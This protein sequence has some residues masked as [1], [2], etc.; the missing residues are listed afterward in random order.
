M[1]ENEFNSMKQFMQTVGL[2]IDDVAWTIGRTETI[3][4]ASRFGYVN[5]E[6]LVLNYTVYVNYGAGYTLFANFSTGILTYRMPVTRYNIANEYFESVAPKDR[7]FLLTGTSAPV[8]HVFVVE[9]LPMNDGEFI[10]VIVAPSIRM[11]NSSISTGG[12]TKNYF[13]FYLPI[14]SKGD[15]PQKSQSTTLM[16]TNVSS[17]NDGNITSVRLRVSFPCPE[18]GFDQSFFN[19]DGVEEIV[20][21]PSGSVVEFYTGEVR[22]SLGLYL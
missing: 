5:F 4:Y 13:K 9:K 7:S 22:V 3:R 20:T 10:R 12:Q 14:L 11:L 21:V 19:F 17:V 1:A 15:N 6:S 8:T 18:L 2:Q 16:G